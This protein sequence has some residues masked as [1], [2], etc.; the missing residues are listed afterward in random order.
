MTTFTTRDATV[1]LRD[2]LLLTSGIEEPGRLSEL[3]NS[4]QKAF[5]EDLEYYRMSMEQ[6]KS[7]RHQYEKEQ[8]SFQHIMTLI[9]SSVS[10][11]LLRTCCLPDKTLREWIINL[12][13]TVGVSDRTE[14]ERARE[15]YLASL[16]PM[17]TPNQWDTWLAEYDQAATEAEVYSVPEVSQL[18]AMSKDFLVAVQKTA[19]IWAVNFQE[20]GRWAA[21][22][23]RKEM[24]NRFREHMMMH[25][26]LFRSG[27]HKAAMAA[28]D[29]STHDDTTLA[30]GASYQPLRGT[31]SSG[32]TAPSTNLNPGNTS[33]TKYRGR[34]RKQPQTSRAMRKPAQ[35]RSSAQSEGTT[36]GQKCPACYQYHELRACYYVN[37]DLAPEWW[38][39]N[40]ATNE[41]IPYTHA[42]SETITYTNAGVLSVTNR[43][44]RRPKDYG[45]RRRVHYHRTE[46]DSRAHV[47]SRTIIHS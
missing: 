18:D 24:M 23:S 35:K 11:H 32:V 1:T 26:P 25:H 46:W 4:G 17:R 37:P 22:M 45:R 21:G 43:M 14:K 7:D 8:S 15:R 12:K 13:L 3:S 42:S 9:Q 40:E 27:K 10:P 38:T 29:E 20:N 41:L 47:P 28:Y 36:S 39:P 30:G 33:Q 2:Q 16:K 19:P 6:Y 5:K 31:P 44:T 34:P